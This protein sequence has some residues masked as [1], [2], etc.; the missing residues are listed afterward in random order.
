MKF[1]LP[2]ILLTVILG[3]NTTII[4]LLTYFGDLKTGEKKKLTKS[5]HWTVILLIFSLIVVVYQDFNN[6]II[7]RK[8]TNEIKTYQNQKDSIIKSEVKFGIE[9]GNRELFNDLSKAFRDQNLIIQELNNRLVIIQDSVS[10]LKIKDNFPVLRLVI[11]E[12]DKKN[13]KSVYLD[14]DTLSFKFTSYINT[15]Y[16]IEIQVL[17]FDESTCNL[18]FESSSTNS[19]VPLIKD[20][21]RTLSI[22]LPK[23]I[24]EYNK[25]VTILFI[26]KYSK[27]QDNK[28]KLDFLDGKGFNFKLGKELPYLEYDLKYYLD[29]L[30]KKGNKNKT[31]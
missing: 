28:E 5:G 1:I 11:P 12:V 23:R 25:D 26:G 13:S 4:A 14:G 18:L 24:I 15:S 3:I 29:K 16:N 9:K 30:K 19:S 22:I 17:I 21:Y 31:I 10:K 27:D 6:K 8:N 20:N 2:T 7:E